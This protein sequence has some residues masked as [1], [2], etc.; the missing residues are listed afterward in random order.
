MI[1]RARREH[2]D[3][4]YHFLRN[5]VE[6]KEV[7]LMYCPTNVVIADVSTKGLAKQIFQAMREQ[8]GVE[9]LR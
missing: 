3:I 8:L 7:E 5:A 1:H 6:S 9:S 2:I 4:K